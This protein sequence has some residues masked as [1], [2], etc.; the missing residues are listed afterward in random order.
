MTAAD[1]PIELYLD[2]VAGVLTGPPR[3]VRHTLAEVEAHLLDAA[4]EARVRGLDEEA[5]RAEAVHRMGP[6]SGVAVRPWADPVLRRGAA[7]AAL[8]AAGIGGLA[9]G[10]AGLLAVLVRAVWGD[11]AV[12]TPF[13]AGS[14]GPADCARWQAV[15]PGL[16]CVAAM[17]ADHADDF[18]RNAVVAAVAGLF[19][20]LAYRAARRRW[21]VAPWWVPLVGFGLAGLAA[22]GLVGIGVDGL[23]STGTGGWGQSFSL[24]AAAALATVWFATRVRRSLPA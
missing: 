9:V 17:T 19:P 21:P 14:Y 23:L 12:A 10:L 24:A 7:L 3:Q 2:R 22:V 13:P 11:G 4:A 15:R 6:V 8:L 20:L 1:D 18:V 16:D 5:A